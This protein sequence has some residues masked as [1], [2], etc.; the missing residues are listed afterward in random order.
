MEG[1]KK[2]NEGDFGRRKQRVGEKYNISK[3]LN[4]YTSSFIDMCVYR[5]LA[6]RL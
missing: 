6:A 4:I 5:Y 1:R 3:L 2:E